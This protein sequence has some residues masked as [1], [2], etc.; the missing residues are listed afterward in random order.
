M[1]ARVLNSP[2]VQQQ[3]PKT[4]QASVIHQVPA[5]KPPMAIRTNQP[6]AAHHQ[7]AQAVQ[8]Q[9]VRIIQQ[10]SVVGQP[11]MVKVIQQG[12]AAQPATA[13]TPVSKIVHNPN[14]QLVSPGQGTVLY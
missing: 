1:K 14:S 11:S 6:A 8:Q 10:P 9:Q 3:Q 7:P 4:P 12:P 5:K 2:V 13:A